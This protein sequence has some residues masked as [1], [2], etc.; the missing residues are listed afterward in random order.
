MEGEIGVSSE[1]GKGSE[2]WFELPFTVA[3]ASKITEAFDEPAPV[4]PPTAVQ[5]FKGMRVLVAEDND[6]NQM[7][8]ELLLNRQGVETV[9]VGDGAA[10]VENL[11]NEAYDLVFMDLEMPIMGGFEAVAAIREYEKSQG[12]HNMI[13]ALSAHAPEEE[14]DHCIAA[15]MDD[16]LMKPIDVKLLHAMLGKFAPERIRTTGATGTISAVSVK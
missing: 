8:I 13:V 11:R 10:A 16:Y 7:L 5:A 15:G 4:S 9:I 12:R 3:D 6:N 1:S 14:R 2:F